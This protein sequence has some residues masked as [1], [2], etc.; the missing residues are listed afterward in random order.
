MTVDAGD[1]IRAQQVGGTAM[2]DTSE[3]ELGRQ[4]AAA[5][6]TVTNVDVDELFAYIRDLQARVEAVEADREAERRAGKPDLV[7]TAELIQGHIAHRARALGQG[8]V[9][10]QF[11]AKADALVDAAKRAAETGDGGEVRDMASALGAGIAR[12]AGLAASADVSYPLQLI[13][14]DLPEVL[15]G[16]H[17]STTIAGQVI[18]SHTAP[19]RRAVGYSP[20]R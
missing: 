16:L 3:A 19:P 12:V 13:T 7:T 15:A 20:V 9:L 2:H 8:G 5:G 17:K 4:A 10:D 11:L 1:A 18:S 6:A 14:E